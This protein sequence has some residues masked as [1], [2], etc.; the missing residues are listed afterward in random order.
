MK[1][2]IDAYEGT[3]TF[4]QIDTKDALANTYASIFP[5]L[6]KP[7]SQMPAGLQAHI[8]Y[9]RDL[10]NL[11][12]EMFT[13]FHMTDPTVFYL[14][15]DLWNIAKENLSQGGGASPIRSMSWAADCSSLRWSG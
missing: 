6:F 4:Y 3:T 9:P 10:F 15:S 8:R 14:R 5:G 2:V 1:V 11:Q 12:A 7:F 13:Y